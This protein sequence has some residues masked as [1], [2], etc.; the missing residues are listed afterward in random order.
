MQ[1][2]SD[3]TALQGQMEDC[4]QD[5]LNCSSTCLDTATQAMEKSAGIELVR[6]LLDC[7]EMS[8]TAAHFMLRNSPLHGYTCQACG[9]I[10]THCADLCFQAGYSD[11]GNACQA[12][13]NSCQQMMK[14]MA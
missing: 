10:C 9:S 5:C 1:Q 13:A 12:C 7:S 2:N 14:M 3:Q 8:Q 4:I 11:C 6:S